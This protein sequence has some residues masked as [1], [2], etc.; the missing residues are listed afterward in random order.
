MRIIRAL[1]LLVALSGCVPVATTTQSDATKTLMLKD[2]AYEPNIRTIL[3]QPRQSMPGTTQGLAVTAVDAPGL[4]LE[5]DDLTNS[6]QRYMARLIHC[7]YDWT[8]ST[9]QDL[10]FLSTYN[11][12]PIVNQEYSVDTHIPYI[13]YEVQLPNVKIPGNYVVAVYRE[14]D[15]NDIVLTRR[16]MVFDTRVM[17]A[18]ANN[19]LGPGGI[20]DNNQQ[21]NFSVSY[22]DLDVINPLEN[23]RVVIRQN[24]RWDNLKKDIK[25]AFA[26]E[27]DRQLDYRFFDD[28]DLFRGG[29]EFRFFDLRSL[30]NPGRN[31]RRVDY[32]SKPY[33]V[34][35]ELDK[36]RADE[37]YS[38]YPDLNGNFILDNYDYRDQN[39]S[40]YAF[41][42]FTLFTQTPIAGNIYVAGSFN[43]WNL[44]EQNR[45]TYDSA[46]RTYQSEILLKQGWYDYQYVVDGT[47]LQKLMMEGS[48]FETENEYEIFVYH[49]PFKPNADLLV[50]YV[51]LTKNARR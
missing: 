15:E 31:V 19:L 2:F 44:D 42:R 49:R 41:V 34:Q 43:Y 22:R 28:S 29:N 40:N 24:G 23:I 45:M 14:G 36:S 35:I 6:V 13:H 12:T 7:N 3:L 16:F 11:E 9:L 37:A 30:I 50:G 20:A 32:N 5:F 10:D 48:H 51:R 47:G 4:I 25:P 17:V 8:K 1:A 38:Q 18:G 39:F 21:L 26:N 33:H 27:I 46:S